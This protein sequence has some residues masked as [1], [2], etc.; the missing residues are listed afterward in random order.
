[1]PGR[2]FYK[3]ECSDFAALVVFMQVDRKKQEN[4]QSGPRHLLRTA[5]MGAAL[6][7][8]V[9]LGTSYANPD[10]RDTKIQSIE[11]EQHMNTMNASI[12][13]DRLAYASPH[14]DPASLQYINPRFIREVLEGSALASRHL[15]IPQ[16]FILAQCLME[17]GKLQPQGFAFVSKNNLGGMM[18]GRKRPREY[19]SVYEFYASYAKVLENDGVRDI[20]DFWKTV[21]K[22]HKS[23]YFVKEST[24]DYGDKMLGSASLLKGIFPEYGKYYERALSERRNL[25]PKERRLYAQK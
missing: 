6:I 19:R 4:R 12:I 25:T 20:Q 8:G 13:S 1:M 10:L 14:K 11:T 18:R 15:K 23:H 7:G 3:L 22:L 5:V 21:Y 17:S 9:V 16:T 2:K 24:L